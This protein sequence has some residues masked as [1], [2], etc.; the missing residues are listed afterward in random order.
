MQLRPQP[1]GLPALYVFARRRY[2]SPGR[3]LDD[4]RAGRSSGP[5]DLRRIRAA[6]EPGGADVDSGRLDADRGLARRSR[7]GERS[8][9]GPWRR[10]SAAAW[11][12]CRARPR[13]RCWRPPGSSPSSLTADDGSARSCSGARSPALVCLPWAWATLREYGTPFYSYTSYFEYNFSWTVHHYEKGNTLPSQF[14][15]LANLPEIV[16]V[17]IKSLLL[18]V[19]YSTMIVGLPIVAGLLPA[20]RPARRAGT[21]NRPAGRDDLRG[22]RAGDAQE[23][24]RRDPGRPAR[25]LLLAG[26]RAHAARGRR[27]ADRAGWMRRARAEDRSLA[28]RDVLA[29][30]SGPT[31]PGPT[32]RRG[33]SSAISFTGRPCARP[34]SGSRPIP[35]EC[36][37]RPG[38]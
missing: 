31:R 18:I 27:G 22:V 4:G 17:K 35:T 25:A 6:R 33:W 37:P 2:G 32:T 36:P 28:G 3:D 5:C 7:A 12:S 14:Y 15:T 9:P 30:W 16:R 38:S 29:L 21:R 20:A 34:A 19:V 23:H 1:A 10:G 26:L 24:R 13:W 11:P 8:G